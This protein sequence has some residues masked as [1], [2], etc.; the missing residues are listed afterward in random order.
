MSMEYHFHVEIFLLALPAL[1]L[2]GLAFTLLSH[3]VLRVPYV[4]T[5]R[6]VA[7]AMVRMADLRGD[8]VVMDLGA[9]D[10][11]VLRVAKRHHPGIQALGCEL[12]FT[13]WLFGWLRC[14]L[15]RSGV[16][17][18]LRNALKEDVSRAGVLFLYLF[19]SLM[20][21]LE[22]KFDR[23]LHPGTRV[24]AHTFRFPRRQPVRE[25]VI[26]LWR[27]PAKIFLYRW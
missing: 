15:T 26:P 20:E 19:P 24:V 23:E 4:P 12:V 16:A 17:L 11:C 1:L 27:G 6:R 22:E 8:E 14:L 13:V 25:E 9:G 5:P 10:G 3:A 18:R 21:K 7:E 2:V